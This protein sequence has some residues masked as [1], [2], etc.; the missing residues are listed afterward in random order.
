M[1]IDIL[2]V[3]FELKSLAGMRLSFHHIGKHPIAF[4]LIAPDPQIIDV[5]STNPVDKNIEF[6]RESTISVDVL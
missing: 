1:A 4:Y 2:P 6:T 3:S 5:V